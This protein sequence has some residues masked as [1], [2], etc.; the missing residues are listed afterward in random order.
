MRGMFY[1]IF[2]TVERENVVM[3]VCVSTKAESVMIQV[4]LMFENYWNLV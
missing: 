1:F 2:I 3:D 4:G